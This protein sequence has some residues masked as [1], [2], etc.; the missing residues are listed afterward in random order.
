[1]SYQIKLSEYITNLLNKYIIDNCVIQYINEKN[2]LFVINKLFYYFKQLEIDNEVTQNNINNKI[3]YIVVYNLIKMLNN[4][5]IEILCSINKQQNILTFSNNITEFNNKIMSLSNIKFKKNIYIIENILKNIKNNNITTNQY[6]K[7]II[8]IN[9]DFDNKNTINKL[10]ATF[11]QVYLLCIYKQKYWYKKFEI[12][13]NEIF[14][15]S[16]KCDLNERAISISNFIIKNKKENLILLDGHGR[17]INAFLNNF[18]TNNKINIITCDNHLPTY[19]WHCL[20]FD[21][22]YNNVIFYNLFGNIFSFPTK[23]NCKKI[24]IG[25]PSGVLIHCIKENNVVNDL[26][27]YNGGINFNNIQYEKSLFYLNFCGIKESIKNIKILI[28]K[29]NNFYI[30]YTSNRNGI[31]SANKILQYIYKYKTKCEII[32]NRK[33]FQTILIKKKQN[34]HY[35]KKYIKTIKKLKNKIFKINN[36]ITKTTKL[37]YRQNLNKIYQ[38]AILKY[39]KNK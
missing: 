3:L 34:K 38:K 9:L 22:K 12:N 20:L 6:I 15:N 37:I 8:E 2:I 1:M 35:F 5:D 27:I 30:S 4:E 21:K 24:L 31:Y 32:T 16:R 28:K 17:M 10:Q 33:I 11:E 25:K 26:L 18:N 29:R 14:E 39:Y 19:L 13:L 7:S 36:N 23:I